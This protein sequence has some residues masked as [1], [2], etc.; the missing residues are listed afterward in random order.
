MATQ[1]IKT[2]GSVFHMEEDLYKPGNILF[3]DQSSI[4]T[5]D[6]TNTNVVVGSASD[7]GYV[8]GVGETA[9]FK[10]I[11]GFKQISKFQVLVADGGNHCVRSID[12]KTNQTS[13]YVGVPMKEGSVDGPGGIAEFN[14]P[15]GLMLVSES[16]LLISDYLSG[17]IR[18][19]N[20]KTREVSTYIS[21]ITYP[22][23]MLMHPSGT[24]FYCC[25]EYSVAEIDIASR[26]YNVLTSVE[27]GYE[28]SSID[29][30]KFEWPSSM[31]WLTPDTL[32]VADK[33]S[34]GNP[35]TK[36]IRVI[37]LAQNQV[38]SICL[39]VSQSPDKCPF[40]RVHSVLKSGDKLYIG[41]DGSINTRNLSD[42]MC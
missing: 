35:N 2:K 7:R 39:S 15:C 20:R 32:V 28:D 41:G 9:R 36:R 10:R 17:A 33:S 42:G 19:V 5:T 31:D 21:R 24:K 34:R 27:A 16:S 22:K 1:Y 3:V 18:L 26:T 25:M 11:F 40:Y 14:S 29:E 8:E 12:R 23:Q 4:K 6:G 13:L 37:S 38:T 30:S